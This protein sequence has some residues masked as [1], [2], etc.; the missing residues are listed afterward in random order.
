MLP[1]W[2][3]Q[4]K[5][6]LFHWFVLF[7]SNISWREENV[8]LTGSIALTLLRQKHSWRVLIGSLHFNSCH[9]E[10][11]HLKNCLHYC[12]SF[13]ILWFFTIQSL[14]RGNMWNN[15]VMNCAIPKLWV[16]PFPFCSF[17]RIRSQ[18]A[19]I[20]NNRRAWISYRALRVDYRISLVLPNTYT[21]IMLDC[22][23][24]PCPWSLP[25]FQRSEWSRN[26]Y[27]Y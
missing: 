18:V 22:F 7:E 20:Y 25:L 9:I 3:N 17:S 14:N 16:I 15:Y 6:L 11:F 2:D 8:I 21:M 1:F 5:A 12:S 13:L 10:S 26:I 19:I 24:K 4:V 27:L 23:K